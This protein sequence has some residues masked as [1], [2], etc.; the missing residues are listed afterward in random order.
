MNFHNARSKKIPAANQ[1]FRKQ[2]PERNQLL[3]HLNQPDTV[4]QDGITILEK[5]L[6]TLLTSE[7]SQQVVNLKF[8]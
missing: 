1:L 5:T 3:Q 6:K 7:K 4:V 8:Q 2:E